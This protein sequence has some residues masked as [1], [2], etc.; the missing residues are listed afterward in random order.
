MDRAAVYEI[1]V[2]ETAVGSEPMLARRLTYGECFDG[3]ASATVWLAFGFVIGVFT[4]TNSVLR[5]LV[6]SIE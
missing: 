1:A 6:R 3:R 5:E 4:R 2:L